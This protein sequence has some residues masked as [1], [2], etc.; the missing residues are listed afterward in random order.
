MGE[1]RYRIIRVSRISNHRIGSIFGP[2]GT[3]MGTIILVAGLATVYFSLFS[4]LLILAGAF[5]AFS[6]SSTRIVFEKKRIKFSDNIFGVVPLGKWISIA[7]GMKTG[8]K[9]TSSGWRL[10]SMGNRSTDMV[11]NDF[12]LILYDANGKEIA[13][14][15]KTKDAETARKEMSKINSQ[16]GIGH[17]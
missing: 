15:M 1:I 9:K 12:R 17:I 13:P 8:I 16:F 5:L 11:T 10:Y 2:A 3:V 7:P 14:L 4:I 6:H